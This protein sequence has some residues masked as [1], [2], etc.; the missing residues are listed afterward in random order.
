MT[1]Y[2]DKSPYAGE[3]NSHFFYREL[4]AGETLEYTLLFVVDEDRLDNL[5]LGFGLEGNVIPEEGETY[6]E[7]YV[8]MNVNK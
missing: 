8:R 4:G 6:A 2:F 1:I 3:L 5:Y 7:R